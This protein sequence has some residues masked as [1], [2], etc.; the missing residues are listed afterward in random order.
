[1][2]DPMSV[3]FE[4]RYPWGRPSPRTVRVYRAVFLTV[5]HRDKGG[6]D[7]ACP[8]WRR[9]KYHVHHYRFQLHPWQRLR[10]RFERCAVCGQRMGRAA[11]L[12]VGREGDKVQ[13]FECAG[14]QVAQEGEKPR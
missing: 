13:H 7:G 4:V 11:R 6:V 1:M 10:H 12:S 5:W 9:K 3:I 8:N 14:V 2:H